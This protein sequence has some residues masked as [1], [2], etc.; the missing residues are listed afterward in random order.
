MA[1]DPR[2]ADFLAKLPPADGA[3]ASLDAL[4]AAGEMQLR[5]LHGPLEPCADIRTHTVLS[6]DNHPIRIRAYTPVTTHPALLPAIVY[7]HGGGW[8]RCSLD[9]YDNPCTALAHATGCIVLSVDY[10][11]APE[12]KFPV[13]LND[14][15]T[16]LSW[17]AS[18]A[19]ELGIDHS[20]LVVGGDSSGGNLAAAAALR[21]RDD[22]RGPAIAHQLLMY[23]PLDA[24][25]SSTSYHE[26][27]T[28][29]FLTRST[30]ESC[31]SAYLNDK[32]DG[33]SPWA[34]PLKATSLSNLPAATIIVCE[35][36]PLRDEGEAYARRLIEAGIATESHRLQG[37]VHACIHM[38]GVTPRARRLFELAGSSLRRALN[39]AEQA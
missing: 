2:I 12:N 8:S 39:L 29:Y 9:L 6:N 3:V 7:A 5:L 4:R 33:D 18:H 22:A 31:W 35:Y 28:G 27:A 1:L 20:R 26:F 38:L 15:Y 37:M 25:M 10:R 14:Y 34:S 19:D 21:A 11:L 30:M 24:A 13:P 16:A 32:A 17:I 23:P 36:D